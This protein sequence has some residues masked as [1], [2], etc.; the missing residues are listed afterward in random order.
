MADPTTE[1]APERPGDDLADL[2]AFMNKVTDESLESTRRMVAL[3]EESKE[4]GI[5]TLVELDDQAEKLEHIEEGMDKIH[6]DMGAAEKAL[7][8]LEACCGIF[9]CPW[10]KQ[11]K[12][13]DDEAWQEEGAQVG[14]NQP[15]RM[16]GDG[17]MIGGSFVTKITDDDR[18][19][20]M[21]ENVENVSN[22]VGN[23]RNMAIDAG[24]EL[25]NQNQLI[26]RISKKAKANE[27]RIKDANERAQKL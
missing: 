10:Q 27:G 15:Q 18:E 4:A 17:I 20:E 3:A 22:M 6:E 2:T 24:S 7:E 23:L 14:T 25:D 11:G 16:T 26:D 13:K 19:K 1:A 21:E 8:G 9:V 12:K 5:K